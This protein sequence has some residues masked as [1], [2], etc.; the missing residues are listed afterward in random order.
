MDP[1]IPLARYGLAFEPVSVPLQTLIPFARHARLA[2]VLHAERS[3]DLPGKV[4]PNELAESDDRVDFELATNVG[5]PPMASGDV[6]DLV[7]VNDLHHFA[8]SNVACLFKLF[9]RDR[10]DLYTEDTRQCDDI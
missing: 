10:I 4:F 7:K 2:P 8:A 5:K 3:L 9:D 6:G 1:F